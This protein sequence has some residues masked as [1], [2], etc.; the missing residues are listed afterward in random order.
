MAAGR[1]S[2]LFRRFT[3]NAAYYVRLKSGSE[4][5]GTLLQ[6][7]PDRVVLDVG[8]QVDKRTTRGHR[9][10]A[11]PCRRNHLARFA[12]L[13]IIAPAAAR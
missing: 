4:M 10:S 13:D 11:R 1:N 3:A 9:R 2:C 12:R 5:T 6:E 8:A 7:T